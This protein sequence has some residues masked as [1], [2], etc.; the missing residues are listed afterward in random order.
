MTTSPGRIVFSRA[1][2]RPPPSAEPNI[3][4]IPMS[5]EAQPIRT[6]RQ[7]RHLSVQL[8]RRGLNYPRPLLR[9]FAEAWGKPQSRTRSFVGAC[10]CS[11]PAVFFLAPLS[12][13][14]QSQWKTGEDARRSSWMFPSTKVRC[15]SFKDLRNRACE[16]VTKVSPNS[17]NRLDL[18][19][20]AGIS[21]ER[22]LVSSAPEDCSES[23]GLTENGE[24]ST[25]LECHEPECAPLHRRDRGSGFAGPAGRGDAPHLPPA[26]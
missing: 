10:R 26:H 14:S 24:Q 11:R 16:K 13:P 18:H 8:R 7:R 25:A 23:A 19:S 22:A 21:K 3:N 12:I 6:A 17:R 4:G 20:L 9:S 15:R 2:S 1:L 5:R